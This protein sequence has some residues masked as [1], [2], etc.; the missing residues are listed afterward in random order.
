MFD[1]S[2]LPIFQPYADSRI[3]L[4]AAKL[5]QNTNII[6]ERGLYSFMDWL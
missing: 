4:Y 3:F 6:K 1:F 5:C 2:L